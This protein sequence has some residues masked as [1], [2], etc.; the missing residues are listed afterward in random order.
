MPSAFC[1]LSQC[2]KYSLALR[3]SAPQSAELR[4]LSA[5]CQTPSWINRKHDASLEE[6]YVA[7]LA[8][9]VI[10]SFGEIEPAA[11]SLS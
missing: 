5:G 8:A 3:F 10:W 6:E 4:A 9:A 1:A 7:S 2:A 11:S